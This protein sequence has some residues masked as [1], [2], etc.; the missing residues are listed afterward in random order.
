MQRNRCVH[1]II[2]LLNLYTII[3]EEIVHTL[4]LSFL[5]LP[6]NA[7]IINNIIFYSKKLNMHQ[8]FLMLY[9]VLYLRT[10]YFYEIFSF[11]M[12]NYECMK[13]IFFYKASIK[14]AIFGASLVN[15]ICKSIAKTPTFHTVTAWSKNQHFQ[16]YQCFYM[17]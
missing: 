13:K 15:M 6:S 4:N 16:P 17:G 1:I 3:T 9:A 8:D 2:T 11:A 10:L 5:I 12:N 14:S 7:L